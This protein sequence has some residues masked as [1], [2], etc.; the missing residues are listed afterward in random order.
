MHELSSE[1]RGNL[2][3]TL[4]SRYW[5]P[6]YAYYRSKGKQPHDAED[7]V[8]D[9]LNHLAANSEGLASCQPTG[10]FRNWLLTCAAN[11]LVSDVRK[12]RARKRSPRGG[13]LSIDTLRSISG[14]PFEPAEQIDPDRAFRD[15]WRRTILANAIAVVR[16]ESRQSSNSTD[17]EL[18]FDYYI[19]QDDP[20]PTWE[21]LASR[22]QLE[23][24]K[25]A[26]RR[27]D[28]IKTRLAQA[29]RDELRASVSSDEEIDDELRDLLQ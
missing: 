4:F 25:V 2:V 27:A 6:L 12:Q 17:F 11:F 15:A 16:E 1:A 5:K 20:H 8:Q 18:F 9:L 29:I 21:E 23:S 7:L 3:W 14:I 28:R 13:T 22:Y 10:R 24:W 19:R 26:A